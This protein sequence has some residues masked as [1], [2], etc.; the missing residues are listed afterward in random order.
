MG[1]DTGYRGHTIFFSE[2]NEH[3]YVQDGDLE[4]KHLSL[5]KVKQYIDKYYKRKVASVRV[6]K[7]RGHKVE[8]IWVTSI[9]ERGEAWTK[10]A[11]GYRQ[12]EWRNSEM[13]SYADPTNRK[14]IPQMKKLFAQRK[15]IESQI[16]VLKKKLK[17]FDVK[18]YMQK[19]EVK[20]GE[21]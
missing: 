2:S 10:D 16:E 1:Y 11:G 20:G 4:Y 15:K 5:A 12:K 18:K 19:Q 14:V 6:Y 8:T 13:F 21:A 17:P 9:N 3:W 7:I